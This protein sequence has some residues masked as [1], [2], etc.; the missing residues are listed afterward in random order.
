MRFL[1]EGLSDRDE[2]GVLWTRVESRPG[3]GEPLFGQLHSMR[4]RR[5]M[6][7]LLCQVCGGES[8]RDDRGVLWLTRDYRGD[9]TGWPAGMA[10]EDPPVC[11]PCARMAARLCPSLRQGHVF[12]RSRTHPLVGVRGVQ[13]RP[14]GG[15]LEVVGE[16]TSTFDDPTVRWTVAHQVVRELLDCVIVGTGDD[17][18]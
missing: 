9:W 18:L 8:H 13:Y 4:Q 17:P 10:T 3:V 6:R 5:A 16:V 2:S 11:L 7:R 1:D 12:V 15:R 14:G